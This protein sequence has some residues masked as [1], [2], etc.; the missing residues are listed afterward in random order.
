M[1][2]SSLVPCHDCGQYISPTSHRCVKCGAERP[3]Y[4]CGLCGKACKY[5]ELL[6]PS[7]DETE[8]ERLRNHESG[9]SRGVHRA[10]LLSLLPH[11]KDVLRGSCPDCGTGIS[12][13]PSKTAPI[14]L[15]TM[16][17]PVEWLPHTCPSCGKPDPLGERRL[18]RRSRCSV[19]FFFVFEGLEPGR[20]ET[21][22]GDWTMLAHHDLCYQKRKMEIRH[23]TRYWW[24]FWK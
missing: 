19:C 12:F 23:E 22:V 18:V 13:L 7:L 11:P 24:E 10:C 20:A 2:K 8:R 9:R 6:V 14:T 21:C 16:R 5:S 17:E 3:I 4:S 15:R 1:T